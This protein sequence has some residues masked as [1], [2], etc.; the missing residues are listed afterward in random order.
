MSETDII[1]GLASIAIL[2][3]GA[4]WIAKRLDFPALLLLL[5]AGLLAGTFGPLVEPRELFGE[6]LF[7]GVSML[8]GLLLFHSGLQLRFDELPREARQPVLRLNTV[9][10]IVTLGG[11]VLAVDLVFDP[12]D[13]LGVVAGA[14][15]VVS[16][17]TVVGPLL[18]IVRPREPVGSILRWEGTVLDPIGATMGVIALNLVLANQRAGLHPLIQ[19]GARLGLGVLVGVLCGALLVFFMSRFLV[20]DNME[21]AVALLF[22]VAAFSIAEVFLSEAGLFATVTLGLVVAN[23]KFVPIARISGFGETL[24]VLIIGSLFIVLG[25]LVDISAMG[26]RAVGIIVLVALLVFIVRPLSVWVSL[27]GTEVSAKGRWMISWL[28]PRGVVAAATAASFAGVLSGTG[29]DAGFLLPVV[30]GVILG[31]GLIY[32][33]TA[34][35]VAGLLGL[36]TEQPDGLALVGRSEWL[37]QLGALLHEAGV[38]VMLIGAKADANGSPPSVSDRL[39]E[40]ELRDSLAE[41]GIGRALVDLEEDLTGDLLTATLVEVLGRRHVFRPVPN[42]DAMTKR[43]LGLASTAIAFKGQLSSDE[44]RSRTAQGEHFR[45]VPLFDRGD[46]DEGT[47]PLVWIDGDAIAHFTPRSDRAAGGDN[48]TV[49]VLRD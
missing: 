20:T 10:A 25:A 19:M 15:L 38:N 2:G 12:P 36:R 7:P 24:E 37:V 6:T 4:Q 39:G 9:G 43:T 41:Y 16:G 8:V 40:T 33:T 34:A 27:L 31:T 46:P 26:S 44:V 30:F 5:P 13:N 28:D 18:D 3:V 35:P 22:A 49:V 29:I 42:R 11:A 1:I 32:A 45:I 17:P 21:P 48:G 23:Q 47:G 14:I